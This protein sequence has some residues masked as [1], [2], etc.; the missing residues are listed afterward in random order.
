MDKRIDEIQVDEGELFVYLK[1]GY[2]LSHGTPKDFQH[3]FGAFDRA[4]L[5]EQMKNVVKCKC[6]SCK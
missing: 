1:K 6:E 3:C 5:K 4:E 2:C